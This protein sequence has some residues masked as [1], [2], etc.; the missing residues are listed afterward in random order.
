MPL[1]IEWLSLLHERH[2]SYNQV[3]RV[4][5]RSSINYSYEDV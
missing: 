3:V 4:N 2:L 1:V 5:F